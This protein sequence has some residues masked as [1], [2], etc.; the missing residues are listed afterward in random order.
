MATITGT[1]AS[2]TN[3]RRND[4]PDGAMNTARLFCNFA[5]Y[6]GSS[7]SGALS[8]IPTAIAGMLR[9]GKTITVISAMCV[10][11]G[12]DGTQGIYT[13]A[14]TIS[15]ANAT[16]NLTTSDGSTE[17]TSSTATIRPVQIDVAYNES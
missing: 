1:I 8:A 3:V 12:S 2:V 5:A 7:D 9:N 13:G 14:I 4:T 15:G 16:F 10:G 17:I 6:T 11:A